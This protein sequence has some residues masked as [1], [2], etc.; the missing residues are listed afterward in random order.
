M[1]EGRPARV[2]IARETITPNDNSDYAAHHAQNS[3]LK[4]VL[5]ADIP[6]GRSEGLHNTYLSNSL[7][8]SEHHN[9][10]NAD[11]SH[12]QRYG[13]NPAKAYL[14]MERMLMSEESISRAVVAS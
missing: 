7:F 5:H 10:G 13:S 9:I 14:I 3:G 6:H 12:H 2:P 11:S 8:H 1:A 4:Q